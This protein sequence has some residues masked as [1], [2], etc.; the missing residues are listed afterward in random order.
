MRDGTRLSG[1]AHADPNGE[2][3]G[4][5]NERR[6]G[7]S[8]AALSERYDF[9]QKRVRLRQPRRGGERRDPVVAGGGP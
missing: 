5:Y 4:V 6:L 3:V 1:E 9:W 8:G 2:T 7:A